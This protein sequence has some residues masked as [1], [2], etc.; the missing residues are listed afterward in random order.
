MAVEASPEAS[1]AERRRSRSSGGRFSGCVSVA[2]SGR[3]GL[4]LPEFFLIEPDSLS[5]TDLVGDL[6]GELLVGESGGMSVV[7]SRS[8]ES[9]LCFFFGEVLEK[10]VGRTMGDDEGA[11]L[12]GGVALQKSSQC[13]DGGLQTALIPASD[14]KVVRFKAF[15]CPDAVSARIDGR[16][17]PLP[18]R[19][20]AWNFFNVRRLKYAHRGLPPPIQRNGHNMRCTSVYVPH[21]PKGSALIQYLKGSRGDLSIQR[22]D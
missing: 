8:F 1:I 5:L 19:S 3:G 14:G 20:A 10:K 15:Q 11:G 6:E 9:V 18:L 7:F 16:R 17:N 22:V 4:R 2:S 12:R 13:A 21:A